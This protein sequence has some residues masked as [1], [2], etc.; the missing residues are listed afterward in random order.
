MAR[1]I[2]KNCELCGSAFPKNTKDSMYQWENRRFCS[3]KCGATKLTFNRNEIKE[4]YLNGS[5]SEELAIKYGCSA[6]HIL[7]I[8]KSLGVKSRSLSEAIKISHSKPEIKTKMSLAAT[9]RSLSES[10]KDKLRTRTGSKNHNWRN[11]LTITGSGYLQF[12]NSPAN[13]EHKNKLL[14]MIIC[15]HKYNRPLKS[16]EHV[17]HIDG[18]KLNNHPDNLIILSASDHAK[19]HAEERKNGKRN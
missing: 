7:R 13:G 3:R 5:S 14:H 10:A 19:L 12:T 18:N 4:D 6:A 1:E 15:E 17:H 2:S 8:L 11:G 9:G 16:G